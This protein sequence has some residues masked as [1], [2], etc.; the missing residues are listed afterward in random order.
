[1]EAH[2]DRIA[3]VNPSVNGICT[4]R[5]RDE[6]LS[7]ARQMDKALAEGGEVGPLFGL[8][9]AIK[10]LVLT[11]GVRTTMGSPIFKDLIP[12]I[13]EL[14]VERIKK[15]GGIVIGKTNTPEFGAGSN[16]F[17]PVFGMTHNPY[18]L[19]KVAGGSSGGGAAALAAGM[20]PLADGS[21]LGGSVRNP[22]NFNN[23]FG[24][25]PLSW[26]GTKISKPVSLEW[27]R[28]FRTN[29]THGFLMRLYYFQ[30]WQGLIVETR[31]LL[32]VILIF[33]SKAWLQIWPGKKSL[34]HRI[35]A[36]YKSNRLS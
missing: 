6:L 25:R 1:M 10:D 19:S 23:V 12:D 32:R 22:P 4:L 36:V 31:F 9:V 7:E 18:D 29:G 33:I 2:L 13:D 8:P 27:I 11:K 35:S 20:V 28:R 14:I 5:P 21:D 34:G 16:S 30:L 15:A 24:L 3:T 17:N 26:Q